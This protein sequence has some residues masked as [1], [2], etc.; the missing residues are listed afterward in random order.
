MATDRLI[1]ELNVVHAVE[2][3]LVQ[4]LTAHIAVTPRGAHRELLERHLGE[5]RD[6]ARAIQDRLAELGV[7]RNP[8]QVVA[9]AAEAFVGQAVALGKA[10]LDLLRGSSPEEKLLKNARD[11]ATSEMLEIASYDVLEALAEELGDDVTAGLA[12]RHREQEE[13]ALA[14]LRALIPALARD[15]VSAELRGHSA[16]DLATTGAADAVRRAARLVRPLAPAR[17]GDE[18]TSARRTALPIPDYDALSA[19]EIVPRLDGLSPDELVQV[20]AYEREHR[21]RKRVLERLRGLRDGEIAD[22]HT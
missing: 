3:A 22:P 12:R 15:A 6:H 20:E 5:T 19:A 9:G 10:P 8:V 21:G 11:E 4:T 16:F 14:E 1:R 7:T 18:E 17:G 2:L 13:L